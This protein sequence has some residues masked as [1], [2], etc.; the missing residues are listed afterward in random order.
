MRLSGTSSGKGLNT[1]LPIDLPMKSTSEL[2]HKAKEAG[3]DD[4]LEAE[5]LVYYLKAAGGDID[6]AIFLAEAGSL[7]EA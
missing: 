2:L 1:S 7:G 4:L 3:I 5:I 6:K